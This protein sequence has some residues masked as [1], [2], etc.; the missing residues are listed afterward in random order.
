MM[1][2]NWVVTIKESDKITT[3]YLIVQEVNALQKRNYLNLMRK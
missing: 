3:T 2:T 1:T